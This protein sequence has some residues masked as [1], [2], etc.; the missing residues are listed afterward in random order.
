MKY[1]DLR[2]IHTKHF[3]D[4]LL[5][6]GKI[7]T[8]DKDCD[9]KYCKSKCDF[10]T[11]TCTNKLLNN[12]LQIIC[13]KVFRGSTQKPGILITDKTPPLLIKI[14]DKCVSPK[15]KNDIDFPNYLGPSKRLRKILYNELTNIYENLAT[16]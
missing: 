5:S 13:S 16:G 4:R 12:N 9:Y 3:V 1:S 7:C 6:N 8:Y 14:L 10:N 15:H 11:N 2:Y